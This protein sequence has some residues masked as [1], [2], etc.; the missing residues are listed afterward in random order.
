[1][2]MSGSA[3]FFAGKITATV[4]VSR[5]LGRKAGEPKGDSGQRSARGGAKGGSDGGFG[6]GG[7]GGGGGGRGGRSR[8]GAQP[9]VANMEPEEADAYLR[10]RQAMGSPLPP[11]TTRLK[12]ENHTKEPLEVEINEVSSDLGN[13]AVR[14]AKIVIAPG[15][16]GEPDPMISQLGVTADEILVKVTLKISGAKETQMLTVR[17]VQPADAPAAPGK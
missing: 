4:T 5:G 13:F 14:P 7:G 1:V 3:D 10:A 12:L 15:E 16:T 2:A 11:V 17:R 9:D 8:G 6:G